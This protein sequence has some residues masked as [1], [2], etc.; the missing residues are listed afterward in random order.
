MCTKTK[1]MKK[2][3]T[4]LSLIL[5]FV[6]T[7][8]MAQKTV[9]ASNIINDIKAGKS[10]NISNATIVGVL[11]FTDMEE[12]LKDLPKRKKR[13]WSWWG[14]NSGDNKIE[15][16]INVDISFKNCTFK[17]DVLAYIPD[18]DYSGYTFTASFENKAIFENCTFKRKA[19][20]KYSDFDDDS[21][22]TNSDFQDDSTFK[23]AKFRR[24]S[25]FEKTKFENEATF[26]YAE[27]SREVSFANSVF[28]ESATFKY[29]KFKNGV[30]FNNTKFEEDLNIK[31]TNVRGNFNIKGMKVAFDIDSKYTKING[32]SFSK[33]LLE[34]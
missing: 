6:A 20:F 31:Y 21:S 19:M 12:K 11:D 25:D 27:F 30:S 7:T 28:N 17:D 1:K 32:R 26:K 15:N 24:A 29:A 5:A 2:Y 10:V 33:Y 34:K 16:L 3:I 9:K 22:F 14:K 8:T 4:R 18:S 23:Y 13:R